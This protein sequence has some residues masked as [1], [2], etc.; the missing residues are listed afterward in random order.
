MSSLAAIKNAGIY[1]FFTCFPK[2]SKAEI[3]KLFYLTIYFTF[4][5]IVLEINDKAI[6]EKKEIKTFANRYA[7]YLHSFYKLLKGESQTIQAI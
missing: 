2:G 7:S 6:P 3:S 1:A 4:Y 5:F